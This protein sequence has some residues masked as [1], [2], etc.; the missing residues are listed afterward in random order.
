VQETVRKVVRCMRR[1][2]GDS[3]DD[4][5]S[6]RIH[7]SLKT[8]TCKSKGQIAE[9]NSNWRFSDWKNEREVGPERI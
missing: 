5:L 8:F 9:E 7:L 4:N 1:N 3:G 2:V 6:V